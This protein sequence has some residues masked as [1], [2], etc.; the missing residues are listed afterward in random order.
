M[1][2]MRRRS[3]NWWPLTALTTTAIVVLCVLK[4]V[5]YSTDYGTDGGLGMCER[6][7][8]YPLSP[9]CLCLP[10]RGK[11]WCASVYFTLFNAQ[12][13][14]RYRQELVQERSPYFTSFTFHLW[15]CFQRVMLHLRNLRARIATE[16]RR[17]NKQ[18]KRSLYQLY[19]T[20]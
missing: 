16:P 2:E 10:A 5:S 17:R 19:R 15:R 4:V 11:S 14:S 18:L 20:K 9:T 3:S 12:W 1:A 13:F 7:N 6:H 8:F